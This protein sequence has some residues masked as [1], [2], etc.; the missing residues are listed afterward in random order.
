M[1]AVD[2]QFL[3]RGSWFGVVA[4]IYALAHCVYLPTLLLRGEHPSA[5]LGSLAGLCIGA[6]IAYALLRS[7]FKQK[8]E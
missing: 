2:Y 1:K 8:F 5:I 6:A 4:G 3:V 7:A